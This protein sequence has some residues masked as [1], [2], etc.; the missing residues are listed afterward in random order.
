[1]Q[2]QSKL[3]TSWKF[4]ILKN[5][6]LSLPVAITWLQEAEF[7]AVFRRKQDDEKVLQLK[8]WEYLKLVEMLPTLLNAGRV[9]VSQRKNE[10][11]LKLVEMLKRKQ[12]PDGNNLPSI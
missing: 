8:E 1:M 12:S 11:Y 2:F 10:G 6:G 9:K 7:L 4:G 5:S 3:L